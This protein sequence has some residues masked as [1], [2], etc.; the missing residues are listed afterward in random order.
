MGAR[1][2][3][4]RE[5]RA[6]PGRARARTGRARARRPPPRGRRAGCGG[7]G[8][9][10]GEASS[11]RCPMSSDPT[12]S[13]RQWCVL[14]ASAQRPPSSPSRSV[15]SHSGRWR[16]RRCDQNSPSHSSSS[17]S[18]PGADS[19]GVM[20][21]GVEVEAVR[22]FPRQPA[23]GAGMGAGEL[24]GEPRQHADPLTH[25]VAHLGD[26]RR[27]AAGERI[28]DERRADVHVRALVELLQL[29]EHRVQHAELVSHELS[30]PPDVA[31]GSTLGGTA[32]RGI[33]TAP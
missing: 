7:I 29:E 4:R 14:V 32:P 27:S 16:S 15:I 17:A 30:R 31:P 5:R 19:V 22:R 25:V 2:R 6:G 21:V 8:G 3:C 13:T 1:H 18:P 11:S 23:Q 20:H 9:A 33:G 28:E 12:P 10:S 24:L 26:V